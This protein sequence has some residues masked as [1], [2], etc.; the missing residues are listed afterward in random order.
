MSLGNLVSS[1][2]A[3]ETCSMPGRDWR[4]CKASCVVFPALMVFRCSCSFAVSVYTHVLALENTRVGVVPRRVAW[5]SVTW[6]FPTW[7]YPDPTVLIAWEVKSC[8]A[9][10]WSSS[11]LYAPVRQVSDTLTVTWA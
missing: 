3:I 6:G 10:A 5:F 7:R 1:L 2:H 4:R 8:V 9:L 11:L